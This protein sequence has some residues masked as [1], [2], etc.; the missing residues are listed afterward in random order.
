MGSISR[1]K[2]LIKDSVH[3][4]LY[5]KQKENPHPHRSKTVLLSVELKS[6]IE[7]PSILL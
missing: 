2:I 3:K 7:H 5:F 4:K 1:K 6:Y